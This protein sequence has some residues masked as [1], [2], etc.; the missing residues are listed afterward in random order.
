[1]MKPPKARIIQ[2]NGMSERVARTRYASVTE[3]DTKAAAI[4][5]SLTAWSSTSG[6]CHR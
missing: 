1:M 4:A 2:S 6:D 3:M 5:A